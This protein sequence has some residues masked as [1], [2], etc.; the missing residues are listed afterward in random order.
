LR[1]VEPD[2]LGANGIIDDYPIMR[3]L[4]NLETVKT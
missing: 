2:P 3:H 4:C 1:S